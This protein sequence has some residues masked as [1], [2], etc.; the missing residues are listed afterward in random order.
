[1]FFGKTE[2]K[3]SHPYAAAMIGTLAMI[4]AFNVVRCAKR[5]TKCV[6]HKMTSMFGGREKCDLTSS[7]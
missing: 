3:R 7:E 4:G 5:T 1:M 6:C 2:H